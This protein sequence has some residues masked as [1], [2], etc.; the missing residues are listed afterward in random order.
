MLH[1]PKNDGKAD[2]DYFSKGLLTTA[3]TYS[4]YA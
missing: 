2:L 1:G 3:V 4:D